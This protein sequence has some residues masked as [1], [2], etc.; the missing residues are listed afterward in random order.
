[1]AKYSRFDPSNKKKN[2][3]KNFNVEKQKNS[4]IKKHDKNVDEDWEE[5]DEKFNLQNVMKNIK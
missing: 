1:M 5:Y 4:R 2:R 3:D